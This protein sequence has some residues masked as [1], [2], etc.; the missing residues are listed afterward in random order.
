MR[1]PMAGAAPP[2]CL[3]RA[4]RGCSGSSRPGHERSLSGRWSLDTCS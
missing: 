4:L 1:V 3:G 2:A